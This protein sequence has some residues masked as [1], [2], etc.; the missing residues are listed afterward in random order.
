MV[1]IIRS[2]VIF[3]CSV[4]LFFSLR[5][6]RSCLSLALAATGKYQQ[7]S[8]KVEGGKHGKWS[9]CPKK[10]KLGNGA[11]QGRWGQSFRGIFFARPPA[12]PFSPLSRA[13]FHG[14]W[15]AVFMPQVGS[16]GQRGTGG[17]NNKAAA[18]IPGAAKKY[19]R[20]TPLSHSRAVS[21]TPEFRQAR[22]L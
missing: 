16:G 18:E 21:R 22:Y 1:G 13:S 8:T 4:G 2:K 7:K 6:P 15:P 10:Q 12:S 9:G 19:T 17:S 20:S 5:F 3:L 14:L 11:V